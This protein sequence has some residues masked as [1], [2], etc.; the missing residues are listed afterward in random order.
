ML[1]SPTKEELDLLIKL[2]AEAY[3]NYYKIYGELFDL[4]DNLDEFMYLPPSWFI[5]SI[6]KAELDE[7]TLEASIALKL[8]SNLNRNLL[9]MQ[10]RFNINKGNQ[11]ERA[12]NI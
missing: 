9:L 8:A 4:K 12:E 2:E 5:D 6:E 11:H 1:P 3:A 7:L 10:T